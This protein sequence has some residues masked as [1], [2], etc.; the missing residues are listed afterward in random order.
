MRRRPEETKNE[1]RGD[2]SSKKKERDRIR[3]QNFRKRSNKLSG[4][5]VFSGM[6]GFKWKRKI[7]NC[8]ISSPQEGRRK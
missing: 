1:S 4:M 7:I 8:V 2:K 6:M 5:H 3:N